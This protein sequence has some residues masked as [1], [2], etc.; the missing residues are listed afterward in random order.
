M[1][2]GAGAVAITGVAGFEVGVLLTVPVVLGVNVLIEVR[3]AIR[4]FWRNIL[5][6]PAH[7]GRQTNYYRFDLSA[8]IRESG[9]RPKCGVEA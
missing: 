9:Q 4:R 6:P 2:V 7:G 8:H 5:R 3:P 1:A